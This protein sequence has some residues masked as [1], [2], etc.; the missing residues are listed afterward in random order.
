MPTCRI[1][2]AA[3]IVAMFICLAWSPA[4]SA[5]EA[6]ATTSIDDLE[7]LEGVIPPRAADQ[8]GLAKT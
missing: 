7:L 2:G 1:L 6:Y 4:V 3:P 5:E 8:L